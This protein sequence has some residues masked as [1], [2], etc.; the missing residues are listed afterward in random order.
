[1]N[2]PDIPASRVHVKQAPCVSQKRRGLHIAL[3]HSCRAQRSWHTSEYC[4]FCAPQC[5][6]APFSVAA[7]VLIA[8]S[9]SR[10][11]QEYPCGQQ[12]LQ[13][14]TAALAPAPPIHLQSHNLSADPFVK[15]QVMKK[16][17]RANG[18]ERLASLSVSASNLAMIFRAP[19]RQPSVQS[20]LVPVDEDD[21]V[22]QAVRL[23]QNGQAPPYR[24]TQL[25]RFEQPLRVALKGVLSSQVLL[26]P[27][28]LSAHRVFHFHET[29]I[30]SQ[31]LRLDTDQQ[32]GQRLPPTPHQSGFD[33][34]F[35]QTKVVRVLA[36][37]PVSPHGEIDR[38]T[39]PEVAR[40]LPPRETPFSPF[41]ERSG[42]QN[43][44]EFF[45]G[46]P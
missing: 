30:W 9:Y 3:N 5:R 16:S 42:S 27:R 34:C 17:F 8:A 31:V 12:N 32:D 45:G 29:S 40:F 6:E 23:R 28:A 13:I 21:R 1:M 11:T 15:G 41:F 44:L 43:I 14:H 38:E 36:T 24:S 35:A 33:H 7:T 19:V 26:L 46:V 2:H 4:V 20:S 39:S 25:L 18:P 10:A 22:H 37:V